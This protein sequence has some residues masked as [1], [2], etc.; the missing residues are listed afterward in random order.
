MVKL[1][2]IK[3]NNEEKPVQKT[4][5]SFKNIKSAVIRN[6]RTDNTIANEK[7]I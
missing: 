4:T 6:R 2:E 3:T 7:D 5:V 1:V